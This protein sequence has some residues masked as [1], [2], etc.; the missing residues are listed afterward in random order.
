[1][2]FSS[3]CWIKKADVSYKWKYVHRI[4]VNRLVLSLPRESGVRFNDYPDMTIAVDWDVKPQTFLTLTFRPRRLL[5]HLF[6]F[7]LECL[8]GKMLDWD[9]RFTSLR[10]TGGTVL[11]PWARYLVLVL[12]RKTGKHPDMTEKLL[13]GRKSTQS[14]A[15]QAQWCTVHLYFVLILYFPVNN[16]QSCWD[17]SSWVEPVLSRG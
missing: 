2:K 12:T 8:V 7:F 6:R 17:G 15:L 9:R 13:T 16:C 5:I 4:L 14:W 11:C 10:L 3:F 1:M